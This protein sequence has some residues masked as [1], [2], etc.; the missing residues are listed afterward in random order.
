MSTPD[1]TGHPDDEAELDPWCTVDLPSGV[2]L[3]GYAL[4]HPV[5]GGLAWTRSSPVVRL[6]PDAGFALTRS[7]QHYRLGRQVSLAE[8]PDT[9]A[10]L[11]L[12]L[13]F[14]KAFLDRRAPL[15]GGISRV[16]AVAWLTACKAARHDELEPPPLDRDAIKAFFAEHYEQD[17]S[18]AL[19]DVR[20]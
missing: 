15:P 20:P 10:R 14:H 17:L 7:G 13:I 8:L 1:D 18:H 2:H 4:R 5:T 3:F 9:E 6:D 12:A 19:R 11:A 16:L